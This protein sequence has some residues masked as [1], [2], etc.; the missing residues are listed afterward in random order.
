MLLSD[1]GFQGC[2][3]KLYVNKALEDAGLLATRR[4]DKVDE[5]PWLHYCPATKGNKFTIPA[6]EPCSHCGVTRTL[7]PEC[8][9]GNLEY[10]RWDNG[11]EKIA[12]TNW[13]EC[14]YRENV[15]PV[16]AGEQP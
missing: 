10:V 1:H 15:A 3:H 7:C 8:G 5:T 2:T 11:G 4:A 16:P 9:K 12:C 6:G 13:R 14:R